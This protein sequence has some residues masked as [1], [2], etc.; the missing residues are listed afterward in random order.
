[1]V[2]YVKFL[3]ARPSQPFSVYKAFSTSNRRL[4]KSITFQ[5]TQRGIIMI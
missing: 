1:V 2:L 4:F 3:I 5:I